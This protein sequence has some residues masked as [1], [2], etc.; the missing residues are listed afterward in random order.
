MDDDSL[1]SLIRNVLTAWGFDLDLPLSQ[2]HGR[3]GKGEDS[4]LKGPSS[5]QRD[6]KSVYLGHHHSHA[7][8]DLGGGGDGISTA[9]VEKELIAVELQQDGADENPVS[10]EERKHGNGP[11]EYCDSDLE[12]RQGSPAMSERRQWRGNDRAE[13]NEDSCAVAGLAGPTLVASSDSSKSAQAA[14]VT[15]SGGTSL[16]RSTSLRGLTKIECDGREEQRFSK[17]ESERF[18]SRKGVPPMGV[19]TNGVNGE[20]SLGARLGGNGEG[21]QE[22]ETVARASEDGSD[23]TP[24]VGGNSLGKKMAAKKTLLGGKLVDDHAR[25]EEIAVSGLGRSPE[26]KGL[27][28]AVQDGEALP[29]RMSTALERQ[30]LTGFEGLLGDDPSSLSEGSVGNHSGEEVWDGVLADDSAQPQ[31]GHQESAPAK[32]ALEIQDNHSYAS[33]FAQVRGTVLRF[34]NISTCR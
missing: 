16:P 25:E 11:T 1:A 21:Y 4:L 26:S 32:G 13:G 22:F 23:R 6:A 19:E 2:S 17:R 20:E 33:E 5:S 3:E 18:P 28:D 27:R 31:A 30:N 14:E 12:I 24:S 10:H 15:G 29:A 8:C 9:E 34:A 7:I